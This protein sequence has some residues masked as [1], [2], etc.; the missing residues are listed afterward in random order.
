MS[1]RDLE[2]TM[3]EADEREAILRRIRRLAGRLERAETKVEDLRAELVGE[4]RTA[5]GRE[6]LKLSFEDLGQAAGV[7]RMRVYQ[8]LRDR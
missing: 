7:T 6:D 5:R 2:Q 1:L 8:L 3:A 4:L